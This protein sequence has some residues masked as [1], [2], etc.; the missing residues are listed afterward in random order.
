MRTYLDSK[1]IEAVR[2]FND[3]SRFCGDGPSVLRDI[4][5]LF[6]H[7]KAMFPDIGRDQVARCMAS[8][9]ISKRLRLS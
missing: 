3:G 8:E 7:L 9:I 2:S 6:E 1:V 4:G 5:D